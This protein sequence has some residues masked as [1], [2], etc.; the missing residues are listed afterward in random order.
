M[1]ILKQ[2]QVAPYSQNV[3][4]R[5]LNKAILGKSLSPSPTERQWD[6]DKVPMGS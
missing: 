6:L 4:S 5:H 2:A 3:H 1:D